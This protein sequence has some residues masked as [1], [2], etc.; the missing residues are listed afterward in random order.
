[1]KS[2]KFWGILALTISLEL[3]VAYFAYVIL[4]EQGYAYAFRFAVSTEFISYDYLVLFVSMLVFAFTVGA[5]R[6]REK[7]GEIQSLPKYLSSYFKHPI[8]LG[9]LLLCLITFVI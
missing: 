5:L 4:K 3:V 1:M 7:K 8:P 2:V 6:D 9:S